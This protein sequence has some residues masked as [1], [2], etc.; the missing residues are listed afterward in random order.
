MT[1]KERV[2]T[3]VA[4]S[5]PDR[6][7]MD[8]NANPATM[9][10]LMEDLGASSL[11]ELLLQLHVDIVDIRGVVDPVYCGPVPK[12][13]DLGGGVRE[14][15][16]GI[17][18]KLMQTATGPEDCYVDFPLAHADSLEKIQAHLWPNVDWFDFKGFADALEPWKDFAIMA[19][20]ASVLQH[21]MLLCGM[22]KVLTDMAL[23][24][25]LACSVFDKFT[26]FYVAYYDK[27]LIAAQGR[28]DLFRIG[29]DIGTQRGPLISPAMFRQFIAP[30][31][32]LLVDLAHSHNTKVMFHSCGSI[33]A[34]I[35]ALI[36]I[37]VDI[38]D[39]IQVSAA[40]MDPAKIKEKYGPRI[41][42][43][44]SIDT[45]YVLPQ[46]SPR[47]VAENVRRMI[48]VLGSGGGFI[49]APCHVLQTDV[50]SENVCA[51]Y[52]TGHE[53]GAYNTKT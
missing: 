19:S 31:L 21:P 44:G 52:E 15:Y 17:R 5:R 37:G 9:K 12:D 43:H 46:G 27:M 14:D 41:C 49:L 10:R 48:D 30:R 34:F 13:R 18:R 3:A 6:V 7:P 39:P 26:D 29:D 28:I 38:L 24:T 25:E 8:F 1:S 53:Y 33:P 22:D 32:K 36:E 40:N 47:Q 23:E 45:Q 35:D 20:G 4:L 2:M 16:W 11:A 50:T 51:M 42:L